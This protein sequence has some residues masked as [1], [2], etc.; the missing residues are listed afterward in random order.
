MKKVLAILVVVITVFGWVLSFTGL[1][2]F[3]GLGERIKLGLDMIGGVSVVLEADT[4]YTGSELK[5]IMDQTKAVMENRVNEMGLSEPVIT[6]ENENRIR[7]ELPGAQNATEAI[8]SI[9]KTAMLTFRTADDKVIIDGSHIKD[10][11]AAVYQGYDTSLLNSYIISLEFDAEGASLFEQATK[12]IINGKIKST[13]R[14]ASNQIPIYL[15]DDV[16]SEP[17][18]TTVISSANAQITGRFTRTEAMTLA[19]LIRGGSLPVTLNEVQ[20]EIVGPTLGIDAARNSVIAGIIGIILIFIAMI[21]VYR[22]MGVVADVALALYVLIV[23]WV[24]VALKAVLTLPGIAGLILSVGMAVDSNVIIFSRIKEDMLA[25]KTVRVAVESGFKR[26]MSTIIDSQLTTII[27]AVILYEFGTGS[28]RGFALTLLIGIVAS[29][30]TAVTVSRLLLS[31]LAENRKLATFKNFGV[32]TL[33]QQAEGEKTLPKKYDFLGNRRKFYMISVAVIVIGIGFGLIRGYNLGIDF[34]GGTMIQLNMGKEGAVDTVSSVLADKGIKADIVP[35]GANS[36][37]VIIKTT[38]VV[39]NEQRQEIINEIA[40]KAGIADTGE[41]IEQAGL[42]G[43]SVGEQLKAN[44]VKSVALACLAMLIYIAVRFEWRFGVA[45]IIALLHDAAVLFAFYGL[46]HVQMNSPFI[47]GLLIIIGYSINDTIVVF[48]RVRENRELMKK[49]R[50]ETVINQ[51]VNQSVTRAFMTSITTALAIIP[52][53]IICGDAIRAFALPLLAGVLCGTFSSL[54]LASA[55]YYEI[56]RL[57]KKN[58]YRG[59]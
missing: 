45:A 35:A 50:L 8:E 9:G 58:R 42:I 5:G 24:F 43:P 20:T 46:F 28:V 3:A 26:G 31:I 34:T 55:V 12:D 29:L 1:D 47:A 6:I 27:A 30:F 7:I 21:A 17:M 11:Q 44:T 22:L 39:D 48:D 54:C 19:A 13:T 15:D 25:G 57:T 18:V 37:K 56:Y 14:F 53:I 32:K 40:S 52:L 33:A 51:S 36:E 59:A 49:I 16:I 4:E 10:A 2:A 41:M 38:A 23:L